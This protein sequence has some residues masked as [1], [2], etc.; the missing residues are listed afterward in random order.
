MIKPILPMAML[1]A[2]PAVQADCPRIP[3]LTCI[4]VEGYTAEKGVGASAIAGTDL[5][6]IRNGIRM[7][8]SKIEQAPFLC[9]SNVWKRYADGHF[10]IYDFSDDW[11][12]G[13]KVGTDDN[14]VN[15]GF[16]SCERE[17]N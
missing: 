4:V 2:M 11:R 7:A 9:I 13:V 5:I 6:R 1:L 14:L 12:T 3:D 16:L 15:I 10:E 17:E 8:P